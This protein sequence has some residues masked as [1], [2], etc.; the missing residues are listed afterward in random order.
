MHYKAG[1]LEVT[2]LFGKIITEYSDLSSYVHGGLKSFQ[3]MMTTTDEIRAKD[4]IRFCSFAFQIA[5]TIKLLSL[6]LY[7]QTDQELFNEHYLKIE[8]IMKRL[9]IMVAAKH[10]LICFRSPIANIGNL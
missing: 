10:D 9:I 5:G 6:L 7:Y 2:G 3:D 1:G 8:T 4:Y